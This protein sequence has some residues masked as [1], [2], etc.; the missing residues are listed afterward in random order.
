MIDARE[1]HRGKAPYGSGKRPQGKRKIY[2]VAGGYCKLR[3][4][5][6]RPEKE[7]FVQESLNPAHMQV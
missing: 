4:Q 2:T 7:N 5:D 1:R 6:T 3:R